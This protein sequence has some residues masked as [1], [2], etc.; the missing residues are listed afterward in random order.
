MPT[1]R[2]RSRRRTSES[3]KIY[4]SWGRGR[5]A[6]QPHFS[7][8][9]RPEWGEIPPAKVP[10]G[11]YIPDERVIRY[12]G[13][14]PGIG[15]SGVPPLPVPTAASGRSVG[16]LARRFCPSD[17]P[18]GNT[19]NADMYHATQSCQVLPIMSLNGC[20]PELRRLP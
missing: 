12:H 9:I 8:D 15:G 16:M 14:S 3:D 19:F 11:I 5:G 10:S 18:S 4:S 2:R 20:I 6:N 13:L 1:C 7:L 17:V